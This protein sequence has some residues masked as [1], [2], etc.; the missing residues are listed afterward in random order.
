MIWIETFERAVARYCEPIARDHDWP[1]IRL[2]ENVYE[3]PSPHFVMRVR[4]DVGAHTKSINATMIPTEQMPGDVE[5]GDSGELG[6][7]VI[8]G[9]NGIS[10][11]YIP[12][13]ATEEGFYE[14][15]QYVSD[16]A[17][18]FGVPYLLGDKSDWNSVKNYIQ[19]KINADAEKISNYKFPPNVQK[20][21]HLP[22]SPKAGAGEK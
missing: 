2:R 11:E 21:W 16:M 13:K 10:I 7:A 8:A 18:T 14:Q 17:K 20:R 6:V 15:A 3:I 12:R 9:Y 5:N 4:F 22:P 19:E 1:L